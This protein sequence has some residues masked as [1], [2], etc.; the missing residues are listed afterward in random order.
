M[1]SNSFLRSNWNQQI[2]SNHPE[3]LKRNLYDHDSTLKKFEIKSWRYEDTRKHFWKRIFERKPSAI[4]Q[5]IGLPQGDVLL[6]LQ[7]VRIPFRTFLY[8]HQGWNIVVVKKKKAWVMWDCRDPLE[9]VTPNQWSF[10]WLTKLFFSPPDSPPHRLGI[11]VVTRIKLE[12]WMTY[13]RIKLRNSVDCPR[14]REQTKKSLSIKWFYPCINECRESWNCSKLQGQ[15]H[16]VLKIYTYIC[17]MFICLL[18]SLEVD[19]I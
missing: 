13:N 6:V 18:V 17:E 15:F 19:K 3:N 16:F 14:K 8:D 9:I 2:I 10:V 5:K 1:R 11:F 12:G 7:N 4:Y